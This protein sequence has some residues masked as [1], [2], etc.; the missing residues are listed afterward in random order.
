MVSPFEWSSSLIQ[1][2]LL[3]HLQEET[4]SLQGQLIDALQKHVMLLTQQVQSPHVSHPTRFLL[5]LERFSLGDAHRPYEKGWIENPRS[6]AKSVVL[7][8]EDLVREEG[9][10]KRQ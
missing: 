6:K 1:R 10:R 8:E 2:L 7:T 5:R 4:I 3:Y 9:R